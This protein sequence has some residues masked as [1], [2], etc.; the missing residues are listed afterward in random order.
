[1]TRL[2]RVLFWSAAAFAFVMAVLPHPP[3]VPGNP[4]D[5]LQHIAAF[6]CLAALGALAYRQTPA[7]MLVLGL[8]AFGAL[9]ETVQLI[10]GLHRD[11]EVLDWLADTAAA[12]AVAYAVHLWRRT[13][14][15]GAG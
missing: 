4:S 6:A 12:A 11:A 5:K 1:M 8:S 3:E 13:R 15:G 9:I 2:W 14:A 10:P 7:R